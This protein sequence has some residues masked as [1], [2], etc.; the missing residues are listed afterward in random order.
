M[1]KSQFQKSCILSKVPWLGRWEQ[2]FEPSLCISITLS[3][4]PDSILSEVEEEPS[5]VIRK[6]P[7]N[8][9]IRRNWGP[10]LILR[11]THLSVQLYFLPCVS[12]FIFDPR[13]EAPGHKVC[14]QNTAL[15]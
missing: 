3:Q 6:H 8:L 5:G 13:N 4:F 11:G 15:H 14:C 12:N 2:G 1:K 9:A 10:L 7:L